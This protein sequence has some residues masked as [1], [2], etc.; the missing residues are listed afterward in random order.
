MV[1]LLVCIGAV[2]AVNLTI[3]AIFRTGANERFADPSLTLVQSLSGIALIMLVAYGFD[4]ERSLVLVWCLVV[5][6]FGVFRFKPREFGL[7]TLFMLAGYATVI[8]LLM[9]QRPQHVDVFLGGIC[10]CGWRSSC[11]RLPWSVRAS[12]NCACAYCGPTTN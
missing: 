12:A 6:L 10:G 4:R 5:L 11:P 9:Y 1:P 7:M 3:Y 2:A 8:N